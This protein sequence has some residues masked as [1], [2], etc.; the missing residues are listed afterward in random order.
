[1]IT[2]PDDDEARRSIYDAPHAIAPGVGSR[3]PVAGLAQL[4][5]VENMKPPQ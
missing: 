1:V 4:M 5:N 3:T 2:T